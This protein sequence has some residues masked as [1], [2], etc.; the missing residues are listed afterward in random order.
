MD[1]H[2]DPM[3]EPDDDNGQ[4]GGSG[5]TLIQDPVPGRSHAGEARMPARI[6]RYELLEQLGRG[7]MGTVYA[8]YDPFSQLKVAIKVANPGLI[9]ESRHGRRMR[10]LFFNEAHAAGVLNHPNILKI[11]DAGVEGDTCFIV[12]EFLGGVRTL[13]EFTQPERLLPIHEAVAMVYRLASALDYM[14]GK[15]VVHRDIKPSNILVASDGSVKLADFSIAVIQGA[16]PGGKPLRGVMGTP[17]YMAP[18]QTCEDVVTGLTDI[19]ALGV[20]FYQLLTGCHPFAAQ[21]VEKV[22]WNVANF[23]PLP[24]SK[25]RSECTPELDYIV[26]R[27]LNKSPRRRYSRGLEAAAEL[28]VLYQDLESIK[29]EVDFA[30]KFAELGRYPFF[31]EFTTAE[32]WELLHAGSWRVLAPGEVLIREGERGHAVYIVVSGYATVTK[33][34]QV[35]TDGLGPGECL[36]ELGYLVEVERTATV[37]AKTD[38]A[39]IELNEDALCTADGTTQMRFMKAFVRVLSWRLMET[40]ATALGGATASAP[41]TPSPPR[42]RG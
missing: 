42:S 19:F 22:L 15:G 39:V 29:R 23:E 5:G 1:E 20:V 28:S 4:R 36:G 7:S 8:A 27:M 11:F 9:D 14:H 25:L 31:R 40:T 3:H 37:T 33:G 12:M 17:L 32:M 34:G 30:E 10:R 21:T 13:A 26:R 41:G 6:G 35:V 38:L 16:E 24:P 2:N 18:E